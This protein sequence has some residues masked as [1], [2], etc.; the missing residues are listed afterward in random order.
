MS[1]TGLTIKVPPTGSTGSRR[2]RRSRKHTP[3]SPG[4]RA[5]V[6]Y[7]NHAEYIN[8][9]ISA[10]LKEHPSEHFDASSMVAVDFAKEMIEKYSS[11]DIKVAHNARAR[12]GQLYV[13][14]DVPS[15]KLATLLHSKF[16]YQRSNTFDLDWYRDSIKYTE[17]LNSSDT[18]TLR[19]YTRHGDEIANAY[20]RNPRTFRTNERIRTLLFETMPARRTICFAPQMLSDL[21]DSYIPHFI[22]NDGDFYDSE[23]SDFLDIWETNYKHD[24]DEIEKLVKHYIEDLKRIVLS[25]PKLK[26]GMRVFRGVKKD[27]LRDEVM[28]D[29]R[30]NGFT[31]TSMN[32]WTMTKW[33]RKN[34]FEMIVHPNTPCIAMESVTHFKN[35]FEIMLFPDTICL[36]L[37][38]RE[39]FIFQNSPLIGNFKTSSILE[40]QWSIDRFYTRSVVVHGGEEGSASSGGFVVSTKKL[41]TRRSKKK[42]AHLTM[43]KRTKATHTTVTKNPEYDRNNPDP[44]VVKGGS[45][46]PKS[47]SDSMRSLA[48]EFN[49]HQ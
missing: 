41:K 42:A 27:Y 10:F 43:K 11:E 5:N 6:I 8:A 4:D 32:P 18:F 16:L 26:Q 28:K 13:M 33:G 49:L 15:T 39:K 44:V 2:S 45:P 48:K 40:P 14:Y 17:Q 47:I 23:Y 24:W 20:L 25:A 1:G 38:K 34:V 22:K 29:T 12:D 35:E 21:N 46:V 30:V 31:S 3:H 9:V 7:H 19:S 37:Q 36:P